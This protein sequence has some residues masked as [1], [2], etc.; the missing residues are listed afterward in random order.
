MSVHLLRERPR[1]LLLCGDGRLA[2]LLETELFYLGV[3]VTVRDTLP[4]P[5]GAYSLLL[6]DADE[7]GEATCRE[8]T[9]AACPLLLF[10]REEPATP[11]SPGSVFLRRPFSLTELEQVISTLLGDGAEDTPIESSPRRAFASESSAV[12]S[13]ALDPTAGTVTVGNRRIPLTPAEQ[14]ILA[15][16]MAHRGQVVSRDALSAVLGG[17]GNSVD[18]YVCRLRAK[19]EKPLGRRMIV[20]V[21][22]AGYR[23]DI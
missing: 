19:I 21:R 8:L 6:A 9:A 14:A 4:A 18:V 20:T 12:P 1:A 16:L 5:D 11:P 13:V 10:G 17:G 7:F 15:L 3:S 22:G 2:R 23:M